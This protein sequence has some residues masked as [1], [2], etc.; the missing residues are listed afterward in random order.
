MNVDKKISRNQLAEQTEG[1]NMEYGKF[2]E[3][4]VYV[5]GNLKDYLR[6]MS[7]PN[8]REPI[9]VWIC[10]LSYLI[11]HI[12]IV[13]GIISIF[14]FPYGIW[15]LFAIVGAISAFICGSVVLTYEPE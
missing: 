2:G 12:S 4:Y 15:Q 13:M 9:T 14:L 1:I 6:Y 8:E 7:Y 3:L 11:A 10:Y 5:E